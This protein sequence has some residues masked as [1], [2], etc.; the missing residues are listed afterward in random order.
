MSHTLKQ[1]GNSTV[2]I[3]NIVCVLHTEIHSAFRGEQGDRGFT[4]RTGGN[5]RRKERRKTP[6]AGHSATGW[7]RGSG[8]GIGDFGRNV[9]FL[10]EQRH[11]QRRYKGRNQRHSRPYGATDGCGKR[12]RSSSNGTATGQHYPPENVL[13]RRTRTYRHKSIIRITT[14]ISLC[15]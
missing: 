5:T 7:Q 11:G 3:Y 6:C 2:G 15:G 14:L 1:R 12:K 13:I 8:K 9:A 4:C 10:P